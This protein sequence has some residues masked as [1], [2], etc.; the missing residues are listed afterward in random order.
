V[1][2]CYGVSLPTFRK[3]VL[4]LSSESKS[5]PNKNEE[6]RLDPDKTCLQFSGLT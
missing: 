3:N 2:S 6:Q 5:E 4:P 1:T